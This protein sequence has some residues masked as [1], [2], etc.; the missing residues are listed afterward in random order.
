MNKFTLSAL[1]G[2]LSI[3]ASATSAQSHSEMETT[4][5]TATRTEQ[6]IADSLA[7]VTVFE[8]ADIER[9]QP[10]DLQELLS[11][12]V[13]VSFVRTGGA[14]IPACFCAAIKATTLWS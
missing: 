13:G 10:V 3:A 14:P 4:I 6:A 12:A 1:S 5:V 8:R 2:V 7:P 9:I 11:R